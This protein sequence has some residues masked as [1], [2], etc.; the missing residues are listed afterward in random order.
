MA[1]ITVWPQ[2]MRANEC[3]FTLMSSQELVLKSHSAPL[4]L[5]MNDVSHFGS[6][7]GLWTVCTANA[8][9]RVRTTNSHVLGNTDEPDTDENS[10]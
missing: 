6:S 7:E 1:R 2:R 10:N 8:P 3:T 5:F 9:S 4:T